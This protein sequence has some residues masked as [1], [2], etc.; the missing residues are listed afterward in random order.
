MKI[1]DKLTRIFVQTMKE[2]NLNP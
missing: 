1:I 2:K